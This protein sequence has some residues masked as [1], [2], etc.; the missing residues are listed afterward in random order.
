MG[1]GILTWKVQLPVSVPEYARYLAISGSQSIRFMGNKASLMVVLTYANK[2]GHQ[3]QRNVLQY[4]VLKNKGP[5][6]RPVALYQ[7][8][9]TSIITTSLA[10]WKK[11]LREKNKHQLLTSTYTWN[12]STP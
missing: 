1:P 10:I 7:I 3:E 4:P 11:I 12:S 6:I 8:T 9:N 2:E 5:I